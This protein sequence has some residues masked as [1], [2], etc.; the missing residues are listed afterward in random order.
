[1]SVFIGAALPQFI[2]NDDG[3][4]R[5]HLR[6]RRTEFPPQVGVLRMDVAGPVGLQAN[7]RTQ[8]FWPASFFGDP[9]VDIG[10]LDAP[11]WIMPPP[12]PS[13]ANGRLGFN[14]FSRDASGGVIAGVT[15]KC[16]LT[17][18]D[19]KQSETVSDADGLFIVSTSEAGAHYLIFYKTG[20]PDLSGTTVNTLL[21]A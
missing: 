15:V 4:Q 8:P 5:S 13:G 10:V 9:G 16:M 11:T 2:L 3:D 17:A 6:A 12:L 18:T 20:T 21:G 7:N 19:T 14:G 1:M